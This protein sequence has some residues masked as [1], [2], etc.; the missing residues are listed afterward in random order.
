MYLTGLL[1]DDYM[2]VALIPIQL[3]SGA[4]EDAIL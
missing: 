3:E 1:A 2:A 4:I